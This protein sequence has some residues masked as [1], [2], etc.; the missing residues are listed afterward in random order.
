MKND[1]T[2]AYFVELCS[3]VYL[4]HTT[5]GGKNVASPKLSEVW[6]NAG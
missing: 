3:K 2:E 1:M 5:E 4:S 6:E